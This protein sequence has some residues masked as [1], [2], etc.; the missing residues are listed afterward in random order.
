MADN[1]L[2]HPKSQNSES[3][4]ISQTI[5]NGIRFNT[6]IILFFLISLLSAIVLA[7]IL[8]NAE[9]TIGSLLSKIKYS[10]SMISIV[11]RLDTGVSSLENI[12]ESFILTKQAGF[13]KKYEEKS[14]ELSK[15]TASTLKNSA[16]IGVRKILSGVSNNITNH[17]TQFQNIAGKQNIIGKNTKVG[18]INQVNKSGIRLQKQINQSMNIKLI[19]EINRIRILESKININVNLDSAKVFLDS[20]ANLRQSIIASPINRQ[21]KL[22]LD[23]TLRVYASDSERLA[24]TQ[25]LQSRDIA[26]MRD[27]G[28]QL[29]LDITSLKSYAKKLD[30]MSIINSTSALTKLKVIVFI[31]ALLV[32]IFITF[33]GIMLMLSFT[34]PIRLLVKAASQIINSSQHIL[35]PVAENQDETGEL[36][37]IIAFFRDNLARAELTR[38]DLEQ[39]LEKYKTSLNTKL[40]EF[41]P[42]IGKNKTQTE[43]VAENN[44]PNPKTITLASRKLA[45]TSQGASEAARTAEKCDQVVEGLTYAITNLGK[46]ELLLIS[47]S[48]QMGLLSVQAAISFDNDTATLP[49]EANEVNKNAD[50]VGSAFLSDNINLLQTNTN[51]AVGGIKEVGN[52]IRSINKIVAE[53]ALETST[54]ALESANELLKQSE[55]LRQMLDNILEK[56]KN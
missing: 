25:L 47:N 14:A 46:I 19:Y 40:N 20:I 9:K 17:A 45:Q 52:A 4:A 39:Q 53:M 15:I 7:G 13:K 23:K 28:D 10:Y 22:S 12:S 55:D 16:A 33:S 11:S 51:K 32:I 6:R 37:S 48:D 27:T 31:G 54:E 41:T 49:K 26:Q 35:L 30:G 5:F 24:Q 56:V 38:R 21:V 1:K 3:E 29:R 43:K 36:S 8:I 42:S 44:Q 2:D 18:L 34:R 50:R